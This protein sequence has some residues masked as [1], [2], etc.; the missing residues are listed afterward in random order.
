MLIGKL[1]QQ[2]SIKPFLQLYLF[3]FLRLSHPP[4]IA[5]EDVVVCEVWNL[6]G[7]S[8]ADTCGANHPSAA[9]KASREIQTLLW[10]TK[11]I[12]VFAHCQWLE[13]NETS[14]L[15]ALGRLWFPLKCNWTCAYSMYIYL[16]QTR[17]RIKWVHLPLLKYCLFCHKLALRKT[18]YV[19]YKASGNL[20]L[21]LLFLCCF[22]F[23]EIRASLFKIQLFSLY[24]L[25]NI[26]I[27][28]L[29]I[30]RGRQGEWF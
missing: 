3:L 24:Y 14:V 2:I 16:G 10:G 30:R 12:N 18:S 1:S 21:G 19:L 28:A 23:L 20:F 22:G 25:C 8:Q 11:G 26:F 9:P 29:Y 17:G 27:S 5:A 7:Q 15:G 13:F 6:S 4:G